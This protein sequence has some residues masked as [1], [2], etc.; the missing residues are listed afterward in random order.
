MI[1]L[2]LLRLKSK[3]C[4]V[5]IARNVGVQTITQP[6]DIDIRTLIH[7]KKLLA[8]G[9]YNDNY[10]LDNTGNSMWFIDNADYNACIQYLL[11]KGTNQESEHIPPKFAGGTSND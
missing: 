9:Q 3:V 6:S 4:K 1:G 10:D 5:S 8:S 7:I 2:G 11:F